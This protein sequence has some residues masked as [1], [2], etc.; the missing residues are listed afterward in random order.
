MS[1]HLAAA[2]QA[3]GAP[4]ELVERSARARAAASGTSVDDVLAAWAG[5]GTVAAAAPAEVPAPPAAADEDP[6]PAADDAAPVI[7]AAEAPAPVPATV[8]AAAPVAPPAPPERISL[9]EAAEF[10]QVTTV[11]AAGLKERTAVD[12]PRWVTTLFV[13]L[14]LIGLGYLITFSNGSDCGTAG[15]LAV[16]RLGGVAVGCDGEAVGGGGNFGD[17][18]PREI[19]ALGQTIYNQSGSCA[20]CHGADGGGGAGFPVLSGGAVVSTF[21][22]CADHSQWI[23]LGTSGFQAAGLATYGDNGTGVGSSGAAMPGFGT[24]SADELAAVVFYE[25]VVFGGEAVEDALA[26]CGYIEPADADG[27]T[28]PADGTEGDGTTDETGD[29]DEAEALGAPSGG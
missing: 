21:S 18:N 25:R 8:G 26:N 7:E 20:S 15:Q 22:S 4:E 24:L 16:D 19:V 6:E 29:G 3:L 23:E 14:P 10:E 2:A 27:E 12:L 9:A 1:E 5:G 28:A 11:A 13:V 17:V